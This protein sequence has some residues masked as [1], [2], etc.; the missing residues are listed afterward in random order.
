MAEREV[1][2]EVQEHLGDERRRLLKVDHDDDAVCFGHEPRNG[3]RLG[4]RDEGAL[5]RGRDV[6]DGPR[7]RD[8]E[9]RGEV[10]VQLGQGLARAA[11]EHV[12]LLPP[13]GFGRTRF[14]W[15]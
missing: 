15:W 13:A 7:E 12:V 3:A 8:V 4:R 10:G 5:G 2:A 6:D 1:G 14:R 11:R 9:L